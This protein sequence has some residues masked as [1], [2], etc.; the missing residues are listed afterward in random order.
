MDPSSVKYMPSGTV[1][2]E[3]LLDKTSKSKAATES[4]KAMLLIAIEV[5][6]MSKSR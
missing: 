3:V 4:A 6:I 1:I 2:F 5:R